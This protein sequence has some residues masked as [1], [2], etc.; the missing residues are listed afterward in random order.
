VKRRRRRIERERKRRSVKWFREIPALR[1]ERKKKKKMGLERERKKKKISRILR[2]KSQPLLCL[3]SAV[4]RLLFN[5]SRLGY[6]TAWCGSFLTTAPKPDP[7]G[8]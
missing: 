2:E 3:I 5:P 8:K 7:K 4:G 1:L 6:L